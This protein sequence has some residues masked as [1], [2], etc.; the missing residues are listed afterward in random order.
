MSLLLG[1]LAVIGRFLELHA[2]LAPTAAP[3]LAAL[4]AAPPRQPP[5]G[6]GWWSWSDQHFYLES[7]LAWAQGR[8]D[9]ALHWYPP[10]YPLLG[11]AFTRLTP[12]DPFMLPDL[13]CV[14]AALWLVAAL[15]GQLVGRAALGRSA[16]VWLFVA[17]TA[18]PKTVMWAW[19]VPWTTTPAA[20]GLL[21]SLLAAIRLVRRPAQSDAMLAGF[22][23]VATMAFRPGDAAVVGGLCAVVACAALL[24]R[25][26][27]WRGG[28]GIAA[29][30]L[31]GA[32]VPAVLFGTAYLAVDGL[33]PDGYLVSS[34]AYG[35]EW[36]LLPLRWVT[37]M[38]D[39]KPLFTGG[40][41]LAQVFPWIMPGLAGMV[42]CLA[43]RSAGGLRLAHAA[44]IACVIADTVQ[45]LCYRDLHP[46]YLW[47]NGVYHYFKWTL[48]L[49]A[50]YA[51]LLLRA[52]VA[53]PRWLAAGALAATV[54][55]LVPWRIAATS[56]QILALPSDSQTLGL[57]HG[58]AALD[59]VLFVRTQPGE[60]ALV[61]FG[62]EIHSAGRVFHST[63]DFKLTPW[64]ETLMVQPLRPMPDAP[65]T[66]TLPADAYHLDASVA[67]V[68]ARA[69][70][71]W[72]M[73]CWVWEERP[74][75]QTGF[76]LPAPYVQLGRTMR[77]GLDG[78]GERYRLAGLA[79][80]EA[81]GDWT[82]GARA[83]LWFRLP[84]GITGPLAVEL[85]AEGFA[86]AGDPCRV[87]VYANGAA[88][89]Q[90]AFGKDPETA[91]FT[92]P[93]AALRPDGNVLL[94]LAMA[95]PRVPTHYA[96]TSDTRALGIRIRTLRVVPG[97]KHDG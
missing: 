10:G 44:V 52:L 55:A 72:G 21:A 15:G 3:S 13:A 27:G 89:G 22:A 84:P 67:P 73:P 96:A 42:A 47:S 7:A 28:G 78:D 14:V 8:L 5:A 25:W 20:V 87:T 77:F 75:C 76:L 16:G 11:A 31:L 1:T 80:S 74:A 82:D 92:V 69:S 17:S 81:E 35:F 97:V 58:L 9:P 41:G 63:Y 19:V 54:L 88:A 45:F 38:I 83:A 39:P 70:L 29:A 43:M 24:R 40:Q 53:G 23:A 56:P 2:L 60:V 64:S 30:A 18:L 85:E 59:D 6:F 61:P 12:L 68:L 95:N 86:P 34:A 32:A 91:R 66:L 93:T 49:F 46:D 4:Q 48:P 90:W 26:P 33:R 62:T 71:V 94:D 50:L 65:G 79:A 36:R 37:L 51:L 57:P